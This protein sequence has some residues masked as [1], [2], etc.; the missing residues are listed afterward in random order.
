MSWAPQGSGWA[1]APGGQ[2]ELAARLGQLALRA[3]AGSDPSH[4]VS[5]GTHPPALASEHLLSQAR[6]NHFYQGSGL[7]ALPVQGGVHL[8]NMKQARLPLSV[9]G[10]ANSVPV[11]NAG[12]LH[13]AHLGG[14]RVGTGLPLGVDRHSRAAAQGINL[15]GSQQH[16]QAALLALQS[17]LA[18]QLQQQ[19]YTGTIAAVPSMVQQ[20]PLMYGQMPTAAAANQA[21][22]IAAAAAT[23][24]AQVTSMRTAAG[25]AARTSV[26]TG[27]VKRQMLDADLPGVGQRIAWNANGLSQ[28]SFQAPSSAQN[29]LQ[30]SLVSQLALGGAAGLQLQQLAQGAGLGHGVGPAL[31]NGRAELG[32]G[33]LGQ[34]G[35]GVWGQ[36]ITS[37]A[38]VTAVENLQTAGLHAPSIMATAPMLPILGEDLAK[39]TMHQSQGGLTGLAPGGLRLLHSAPTALQS[40]ASLDSSSVKS[41]DTG[42]TVGSTAGGSPKLLSDLHAQKVKAADGAA[43]SAA[44]GALDVSTLTQAQV[45][46]LMNAQTEEI[47][48]LAA[49]LGFL[50]RPSAVST[51]VSS[52][53]AA[54]VP[55][56][57]VAQSGSGGGAHRERDVSTLKTL[58][59]MLA[60]TGNT[61]ESAVQTGL[62]GGCNAEDVKVVWE[63]YAVELAGIKPAAS[64]GSAWRVELPKGRHLGTSVLSASNLVAQPATREN[65]GGVIG[66]KRNTLSQVGDAAVPPQSSVVA[67]AANTSAGTPATCEL[68][69]PPLATQ[70][71]EEEGEPNWDE[72]FETGENMVPSQVISAVNDGTVDL[73]TAGLKM[74]SEGAFNAFSYGFF[75]ETG[76]SCGE[77]LEDDLEALEKQESGDVVDADDGEQNPTVWETLAGEGEELHSEPVK[78]SQGVDTEDENKQG[79][80]KTKGDGSC[81]QAGGDTALAD[82]V[83]SMS[84][85]LVQAKPM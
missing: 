33:T 31:N 41:C 15:P 3:G 16:S 30:G 65:V 78:E 19:G 53:P 81:V 52:G 79:L 9:R 72:V 7:Q 42:V 38:G 85:S 40:A 18:A 51:A 50:G 14:G 8:S 49:Q 84:A 83:S 76:D 4:M 13:A 2:D 68:D 17:Q 27:Q 62:L 70:P 61:V 56:S 74:P 64:L 73:T 36:G 58:G 1:G 20:P 80:G 69:G 32:L 44:M 37:Q 28:G 26:G 23:A 54:G 60:R 46:A 22:M 71:E 82:V 66:D 59:Q 34:L 10:G 29:A 75:G 12:L 24:A 67:G 55:V 21:N 6:H 35:V 77:L 63:A 57:G 47:R 5:A 45:N 43:T 25:L 11:V 48:L 39:P